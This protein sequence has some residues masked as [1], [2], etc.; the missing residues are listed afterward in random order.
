MTMTTKMFIAFNE[1]Q[2]ILDRISIQSILSL[3]KVSHFPIIEFWSLCIVFRE[4]LQDE[5][6]KSCCILV[7]RCERAYT[8]LNDQVG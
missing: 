3:H 7:R 1:L 2:K 4:V 6:Y 8:G 5:N